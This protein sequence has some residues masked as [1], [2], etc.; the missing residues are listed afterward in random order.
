MQAADMSIE[1][2][3]QDYLYQVEPIN[4]SQDRKRMKD[5]PATE[6]EKTQMRGV[7][8]AMSFKGHQTAPELL[9]ECG[10][11]LSTAPKAK[12]EDLLK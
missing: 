8:G 3:Q 12:V 4:L 11:L 7:L 6:S 1:I 9:A 5:D 10:H 2:K